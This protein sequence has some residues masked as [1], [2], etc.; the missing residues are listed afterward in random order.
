MAQT[1]SQL[2]QDIIQIAAVL[3]VQV[4][5]LICDGSDELRIP[6]QNG[7]VE[8][9][10]KN[11]HGDWDYD[12][13]HRREKGEHLR[14]CAAKEEGSDHLME[15]GDFVCVEI[16]VRF[17]EL[18]SIIA[19]VQELQEIEQLASVVLEWCT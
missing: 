9:L 5:F 18:G 11:C 8:L 17:I 4:G 12:L 19:R 2:H 13:C 10:L 16:G 6:R 7:L 15:S 3:S 1:F 14:L